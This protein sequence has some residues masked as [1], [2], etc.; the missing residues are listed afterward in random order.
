MGS[1]F[2]SG[3]G[4]QAIGGYASGLARDLHVQS[5]SSLQPFYGRLTF[6]AVKTLS[7]VTW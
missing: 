2:I 1:C 3:A 7:E 5:H 6:K 4:T